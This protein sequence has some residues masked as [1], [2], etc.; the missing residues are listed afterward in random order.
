MSLVVIYKTHFLLCWSVGQFPDSLPLDVCL[1]N[2]LRSA[3]IYIAL[4][5]TGPNYIP[6]LSVSQKHRLL[7]E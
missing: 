2:L 1:L 6:M 3:A 4:P 7:Q 5:P